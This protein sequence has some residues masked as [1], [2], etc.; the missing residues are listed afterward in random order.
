MDAKKLKV[1][2]RGT[3]HLKDAE[4]V[5]LYDGDAPVRII[6]HGPGSKEFGIVES[7]QTARALKRMNENDGKVTAPSAE[8]RRAE[9][10]EDLA[11][12]TIDFE[13]LTYDDLTGAALFE[14]VYGD[15]DLGYITKQVTKYLADWGN[16][17]VG[18]SAS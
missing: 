16:F 3:I 17:K 11:T 15:P 7:R 10:A 13:H 1:A 8:E 14:A 6:V 18:S 4:G 12:I 5:P 9:T 2:A